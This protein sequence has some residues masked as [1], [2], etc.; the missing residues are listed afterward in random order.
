MPLSL[1]FRAKHPSGC[2]VEES[3]AAKRPT[4]PQ[5]RVAHYVG[6][7]R[8]RSCAAHNP[9]DSRFARMTGKTSV[10]L[11]GGSLYGCLLSQ[12]KIPRLRGFAPPLGMTGSCHSC[13]AAKLRSENPANRAIA[14]LRTHQE[15]APR[16]THDWARD[17]RVC[18]QIQRFCK[19]IELMR[20]FSSDSTDFQGFS[21]RFS[22]IRSLKPRTTSK[23]L[24]NVTK[25]CRPCGDSLSMRSCASPNPLDS[26]V[27]ATP[28]RKNDN[29]L[30][31]RAQRAKASEV[32]ESLGAKPPTIPRARNA[33]DTRLGR[34]A[35]SWPL[36][37]QR[38]LGYGLCPP[39]GMTGSCHSCEA[40]KLRSENPANRA[41]ARLRT[42]QER[43]T[44]ATHD[45]HNAPQKSVASKARSLYMRS[46]AT[47]N[48]L[49]SRPSAKN[50]RTRLNGGN[51][52]VL[53]Q[54]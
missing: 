6:S 43:A 40:A 47:P 23:N 13:E 52:W 42:H 22:P 10:A 34:T 12:T 26:R 49:D 4:S 19:E 3:L 45:W 20:G 50:D 41:R 28:L 24:Q 14:R 54:R 53:Q 11:C 33:R 37:G 7:L 36:C 39:L 18:Q 16:A 30:S 48:P 51:T 31:F 9:L 17:T 15:R 46:C 1:S 29:S 44:R 8:A 27:A 38:F 21:S 35:Y 32:E 5:K 25:P 2:V